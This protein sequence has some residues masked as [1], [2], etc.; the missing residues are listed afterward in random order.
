[1][2]FGRREVQGDV[3]G[4]ASCCRTSWFGAAI[5]CAI[6]AFLRKTILQDMMMTAALLMIN[7]ERTTLKSKFGLSRCCILA[8]FVLELDIAAYEGILC[9]DVARIE[10][11]RTEKLMEVDQVNQVKEMNSLLS[12]I[13][14]RQQMVLGTSGRP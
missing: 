1:M 5:M 11:R 7:A 8:S 14:Q 6:T 2:K 4:V 13:A 3:V 10:L 12:S 9:Q